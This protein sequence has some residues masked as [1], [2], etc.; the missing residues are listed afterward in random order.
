MVDVKRKDQERPDDEK[1]A[2]VVH[3]FNSFF[4]KKFSSG[5]NPPEAK[6]VGR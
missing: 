4:Y 3:V 2:P 5:K 1:V 6:K